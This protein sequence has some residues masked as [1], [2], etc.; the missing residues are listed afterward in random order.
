MTRAAS[1]LL[2]LAGCGGSPDGPT[3]ADGPTPA[4][5]EDPLPGAHED[6]L[7]GVHTPEPEGVRARQLKRMTIP[8][9]RD[10]MERIT[11][12]VAWG[13]PDDS[14]WDA[15]ADTLGVADYQLRVQSDRTPSV[16]FQ[17]LL[18]DAAT[19]T[20]AG[21][22]AGEGDV[23]FFA[24]EPPDPADRAALVA[25]V[26]ALRRA[27]QGRPMDDDSAVVDDAVELFTMV[28]QRTEDPTAAWQTVCVALFT[29]PDFFLY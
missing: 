9:L 15:N 12:G 13:D 19:E 21:W 8:Q 14:E 5:T 3:A 4:P 22:L 2:L 25:Q 10:S 23:D 6:D 17:K 18:D 16:M 28:H 7:G 26:A 20:C 29:H 11:G 24:G 27:I 1:L